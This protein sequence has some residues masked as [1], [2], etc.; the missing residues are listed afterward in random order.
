MSNEIVCAII[1]TAGTIIA[2]IIGV[3]Y[4]E[5]IIHKEIVP[6]VYLKTPNVTGS[7]KFLR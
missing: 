1:Q 3:G 6:R 4:L 2:A 7:E 5:K